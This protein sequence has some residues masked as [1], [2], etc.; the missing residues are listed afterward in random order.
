MTPPVWAHP[1]VQVRRARRV[2]PGGR[3]RALP[4]R[5][6]HHRRDDPGWRRCHQLDLVTRSRATSSGPKVPGE[7]TATARAW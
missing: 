2:R 4:R 6:P 5:V 3:V 7:S 1:V